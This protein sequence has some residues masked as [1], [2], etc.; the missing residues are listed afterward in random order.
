MGDPEHAPG[1]V[2][3]S[4]G[5]A[6]RPSAGRSRDSGLDFTASDQVG[7]VKVE[8]WEIGPDTA[9]LIFVFD[10]HCAAG[11]GRCEGMGTATR[12]DARLLVRRGAELVVEGLAF[13][14]PLVQIE[15][16]CGLPSEVGV[17]AKSQDR[18]CKGRIASLENHRQILLPLTVPTPLD[19]CTYRASSAQLHRAKGTPCVEGN[20]QARDLTQTTTS[21]GETRG[22]PGRSG[23]S[24]P[25]SRR[26]KKRLR[27]L[28]T[29]PRR[30]VQLL[31]DLVVSPSVGGQEDHLGSQGREIRQRIPSCTALRLHR[32]VI[33]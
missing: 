7:M 22:R 26:S 15:G 27:Y 6:A 33:V 10:A 2:V 1:L 12:T 18:C 14:E 13:P 20:S 30:P 21:G 24:N 25:A 16:R 4:G 3:G 5:H 28:V 23:S 17:A 32:L 19:S 8:G 11:A 9:A 29:T 31:G